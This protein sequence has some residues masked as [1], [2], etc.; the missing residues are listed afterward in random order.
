MKKVLLAALFAFATLSFTACDSSPATTQE[1]TDAATV[2]QE[3]EAEDME[4]IVAP[5]DTTSI[6]ADT[7]GA[8]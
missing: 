8:K 1:T 4:E 5:A 3:T 7:T 2:D 6:P